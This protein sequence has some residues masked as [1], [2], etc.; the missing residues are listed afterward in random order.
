[1][2]MDNYG[3]APNPGPAFVE[4]QLTNLGFQGCVEFISGDSHR[5]LPEYFR[6]NPEITFDL[7]TV[8]GDHSRSGA[9]RDICDVLPHLTVGGVLIFD[10][11][12]HPQHSYLKRVWWECVG[13]NPRF[14]SWTFDELGFGVAAA[15]RKW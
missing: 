13:R 10:D 8:D 12:T 5:T 11:I 3:L 4:E 2:W 7:V 15:I 1:M 14:A 9:A 6:T